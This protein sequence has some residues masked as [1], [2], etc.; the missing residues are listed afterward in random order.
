MLRRTP[1]IG[2]CSTTYGDL[3]CRGCKRFAHEIVQWNG[4]DP[5][6]RRAVWQRLLRLRAGAVRAVVEI[7]DAQSLRSHAARLGMQVDDDIDPEN[8]FYELL[9]RLRWRPADVSL[10][11]MGVVIAREAVAR[12]A[13]A[14]EGLPAEPLPE[15]LLAA[16]DREYYERS[17]AQYERNYRI[18]AQ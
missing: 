12:E 7:Q 1:C 3:V 2:I 14:R 13:V 15:S 10:D 17:L 11:T 6:Q 9:Q 16:I 8:L 18:P 5:S 4:F